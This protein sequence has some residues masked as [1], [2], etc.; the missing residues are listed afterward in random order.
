M[1]TTKFGHTDV[2]LVAEVHSLE[3]LPHYAFQL[4]LRY[5]R[6]DRKNSYWKMDT[7]KKITIY[8][9]QF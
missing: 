2:V 6:R 8:L 9:Y 7:Q 4:A 1:L 5:P 3:G